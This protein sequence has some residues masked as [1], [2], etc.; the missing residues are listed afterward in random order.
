MSIKI[1]PYK[2]KKGPRKGEVGGFEVDVTLRFLDGLPPHRVRIKSPHPT[3][4]ATKVWIEGEIQKLYARGRPLRRGESAPPAE[5]SPALPALQF[6]EYGP[7]WLAGYV[8]GEKQSPNTYD[9]RAR[10]L[11]LYLYPLFGEKQLSEIGAEQFAQLKLSLEKR[12]THGKGKER[13]ASSVNQIVAQLYTMLIVAKEW[14]LLT[15]LPPRPRRIREPKP[16]IKVYDNQTQ[17]RLV[18]AAQKRSTRD[19]CLLLLGLDAGLR[20]GELAGLRPEDIDFEAKPPLLWV[21]W[22][23]TQIGKPRP[24][25]SLESRP[26]E[27]THRLKRALQAHRHLGDRVLLTDEGKHVSQDQLHGWMASI[28]RRAK[29]PPTR[30][31]HILRHTF[32][33]NLLAAGTDI[34]EVQALLGHASLQTT[35][36]YLHTIPDQKRRGIELLNR[37]AGEQ[38]ETK[39]S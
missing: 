28:Q 23:E 25:K 27:I 24:P 19:L 3:K 35:L 8:R 38:M 16:K 30:G 32:A 5:G 33:S 6:K 37:R 7:R 18:E 14:K 15:E 20:A 21:N 2:L 26:I 9:L 39:T 34:K 11:R 22:Q 31:L 1:R 17:E 10:I 13:A 4:T 12:E 36:R 29:L